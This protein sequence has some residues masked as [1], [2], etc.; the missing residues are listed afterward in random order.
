MGWAQAKVFRESGQQGFQGGGGAFVPGSGTGDRV[1]AMLE[2]GEYVMNRKAVGAMG[3]RNLDKINFGAAPRFSNGGTMMLNEPVTS[4][5][6]SGFFLASDNPELMEARNKAREAYE[7]KQA[8]RAKKG[9]AQ[10]ICS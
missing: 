2:P 1:P 7:K 5:R 8:K 9:S 10:K 4:S 6:M 3:R